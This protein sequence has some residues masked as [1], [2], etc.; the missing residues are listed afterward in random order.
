MGFYGRLTEKKVPGKKTIVSTAIAFMA[1]ESRLLSRAMSL[2][3]SEIRVVSLLPRVA[4]RTC[5]CKSL[6]FP[7]TYSFRI[8]IYM[9]GGLHTPSL[10]SF[11]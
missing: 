3:C 2:L 10:L 11:V 6:V 9:R 1:E 5:S 4:F 7:A 8:Y